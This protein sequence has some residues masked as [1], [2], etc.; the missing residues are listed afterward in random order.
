[1]GDN[2][3]S[4]EIRLLNAAGG[5]VMLYFTQ[6]ANDEDALDRLRNLKNVEYDRYEIWQDMR[7]TG[8][9]ERPPPP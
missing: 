3:A 1:M 7:K 2:R 5:T 4:Y 9:G 6:C 8:E